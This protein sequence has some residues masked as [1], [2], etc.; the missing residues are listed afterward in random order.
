MRGKKV[1]A[2][3]RIATSL[4]EGE[5]LNGSEMRILKRL[6]KNRSIPL[7]NKIGLITQ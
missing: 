2:I 5:K 6:N 3:K 7:I 1:T 4:N